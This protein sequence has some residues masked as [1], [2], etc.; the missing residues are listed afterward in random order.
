MQYFGF[1]LAIGL[2]GP[3]APSSPSLV[4]SRIEDRVVKRF[5]FDE[6]KLGNFERTPMNW[7]QL[8]GPGYPRFLEPRFDADVGH[9]APPSM[10]LGLQGGSLAC[11]YLARDI[12]VHPNSDYRIS[13]WI[14][15]EGVV[16]SEAYLSACFLDHALQRIETSGVRS[17]SARGRTGDGAWQRI[18]L[19]LPGGFERARWIAISCHLEQPNGDAAPLRPIENR[20][21]QATA[22]FDDIEVVRLPAVSLRLDAPGGVFAAD[23]IAAC[24]V[25]VADIDGGHLEATLELRDGEGGSLTQQ[26]IPVVDP[27]GESCVSEFGDLPPGR[28]V[29]RLTVSDQ[30]D[31]IVTLDRP[32]ARLEQA[33]ST[34]RRTGGVSFGLVLEPECG[35]NSRI[36]QRLVGLLAP[37][38]VRLPL[39]RADMD[40]SAVVM[41]DREVDEFIRD[42]GP[43]TRVVGVL[44]APPASLAEKL[45][46]RGMSVV[47]VLRGPANIWRPYLGFLFSR[48]GGRVDAWQVGTESETVLEDPPS[49]GDALTRLREEMRPLVG[50]LQI[51]LPKDARAGTTV[52][53]AA[54]DIASILVDAH[55]QADQLLEQLAASPDGAPL[56]RW[57]TLAAPDAAVYPR[58]IR[59]R[60]YARRIVMTLQAGVEAVFVP[61]PWTIGRGG[62]ETIVSPSEEYVVFRTL[63]QTLGGLDPLGRVWLDEG[64]SAWL[65][66]NEETDTG[67]LVVWTDGDEP[68]PRTIVTD[69][70]PSARVIDLDGRIGEPAMAAGGRRFEM[71]A[72]PIVFA[73]VSPERVRTMASFAVSPATIAPTVDAPAITLK[74]RN[75]GRA[76][77]IGRLRV[78]PPPSWQAMPAFVS[79]DLAPG[80]ELA[81]PLSLRIPSN[82][83]AGAYVL[84]GVF[85]GSGA[86][87]AAMTLR[88]PIAVG[89]S[90]VD[91]NVMTRA[92]GR[93]LR[94]VQRVTNRGDNT[95]NLR[96]LVIAPNRPRQASTI[97]HLPPG[98]SA[99]REFEIPDAASLTNRWIRVSLEEVDGPLRH[100]DVIKVE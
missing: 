6:R 61:Q 100:N 74:L 64:V 4:S 87:E 14:R 10:R 90:A 35:G 13:V 20:D 75:H 76:R 93:G 50:T 52:D 43:R 15:A 3:I 97:R 57:A 48:Y 77:L 23:D 65:F 11:R 54:G 26:S 78:V 44:A 28:Y 22:W 34:T 12:P 80:G 41:A 88:A 33:L 39:W 85:T 16:H 29:V 92:E 1:I 58:S 94:I 18:S 56:R 66:G 25:R 84:T 73:P 62:G 86:G 95:L 67:A 60:E 36:I 83:A 53:P 70:G 89:S 55:L 72:L 46:H 27:Q 63:R 8:A 82:Q 30:G 24:E 91:V 68:S 47:D 21:P 99:V 51:A 71:G 49:L 42:L 7:R 9:Q 79:V 31:E 69:L 59:L 38:Y 17:A 2:T 19:L 5:D 81:T 96:G 98:Q 37:D 45:G 40:D 32:F